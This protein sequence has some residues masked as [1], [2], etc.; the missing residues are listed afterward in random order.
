MWDTTPHHTPPHHTTPHHTTPHHTTPHHTTPHHTTPHHT[1]P[2]HTTPQHDP[3]SRPHPGLCWIILRPEG[4]IFWSPRFRCPQ[5][6]VIQRLRYPWS[7]QCLDRRWSSALLHPLALS[8][9]CSRHLLCGVHPWGTNQELPYRRKNLRETARQCSP[10]PWC[11]L[12][13]SP[14]A[15]LRGRRIDALLIFAFTQ[16]IFCHPTLIFILM[17]GQYPCMPPEAL[18]SSQC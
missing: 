16:M 2:H 8:S 3:V 7:V 13:V 4:D 18:L 12:Y 9:C 17:M 6:I 15:G 1:T 11:P 10:L 14:F 5:A